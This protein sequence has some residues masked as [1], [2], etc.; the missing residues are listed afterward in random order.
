MVDDSHCSSLVAGLHN[1]MRHQEGVHAPH[2]HRIR[3]LNNFSK[4]WS[5]FEALFQYCPWCK[6][7]GEESW[8][9]VRAWVSSHA[10]DAATG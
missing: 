8:Q 3:D 5:T 10:T 2:V 6:L 1:A 7:L 4:K 9:G